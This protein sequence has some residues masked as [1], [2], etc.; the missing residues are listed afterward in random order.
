MT[1]TTKMKHHTRK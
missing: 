1:K